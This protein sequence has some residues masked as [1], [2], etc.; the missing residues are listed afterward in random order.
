MV[1]D[2]HMRRLDIQ[3]TAQ[4]GRRTRRRGSIPCYQSKSQSAKLAEG[5]FKV[6]CQ[7]TRLARFQ[8]QFF[9]VL[10]E[11]PLARHGGALPGAALGLCVPR[12]RA[13]HIMQ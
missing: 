5:H 8:N 13:A 7:I 1:S 9:S 11:R 2:P 6:P 10:N 4:M 3:P 12:D